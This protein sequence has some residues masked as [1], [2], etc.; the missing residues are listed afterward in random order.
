MPGKIALKRL[1]RSD[2]TFFEHQHRLLDAGHQ[3]A[4]NLNADV[5]IRD[6]FPSLPE[7]DPGRRGNIPIDLHL[8]GP[9][10]YGDLRLQRKIIKGGTY[11][12]WRLNG[13]LV[14]AAETAS[15]FDP[16]AEGDLV[17]FDFSE[18]VVP[19]SATL[20]FVSASVS[21][22]RPLH[23]VLDAHLGR[24]LSAPELET[25]LR[26]ASLP[27][28]H[29]AQELM[30]AEVVEDAALG[31]AQ[32]ARRLFRRRSSARM[33]QE[34]LQN[35]RMN[36]EAIGREGEEL[37]DSWLRGR[38]RAGEIRDHTWESSI[39]AVAPYDFTVIENSGE[40]FR[41]DVKST[42]GSFEKPIHVSMAEIQEMAS[43][44]GRYDLYRVFS[45]D[46]TGASLRIVTDM[47]AFASTLLR[48]FAGLPDGVTPDGVSINPA[49]LHFGPEMRITPVE[50]P[51]E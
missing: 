38:K 19:T 1:T 35:A 39:N 36:A 51:E 13:E 7:T 47:A 29:P 4:I 9:G 40:S 8:L 17:I 34:T 43:D 32:S 30:L 45:L 42:T 50:E 6:L 18:G 2:L 28:S 41:L 21:G 14:P 15:R 3:K 46:G 44:S 26:A 11:K 48:V 12:N 49:T 20:L 22:D 25:L 10:L 31:G 23:A 37:V 27:D 24:P 5:F 33:T 16:L